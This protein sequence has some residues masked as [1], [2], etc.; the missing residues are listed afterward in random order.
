[1]TA[2]ERLE[3]KVSWSWARVE[4]GGRQEIELPGR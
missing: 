2:M 3:G 1:V 4:A